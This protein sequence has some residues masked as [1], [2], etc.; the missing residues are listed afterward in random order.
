MEKVKYYYLHHRLEEVMF[1][2]HLLFMQNDAKS[3]GSI[4]VKFGQ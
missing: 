2:L 3:C 1:S 4:F